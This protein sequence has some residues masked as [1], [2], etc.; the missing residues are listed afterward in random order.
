MPYPNRITMQFHRIMQHGSAMCNRELYMSWKSARGILLCPSSYGPPDHGTSTDYRDG[1]VHHALCHF[2]LRLIREHHN[3]QIVSCYLDMASSR[4]Q[5]MLLLNGII[6]ILFPSNKILQA[7]EQGY[8]SYSFNPCKTLVQ[9]MLYFPTTSC[10][11]VL[12]E[13][14]SPITQ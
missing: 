6:C 9:F 11:L 13:L 4:M 2:I 5:C 1:A 12:E 7:W 10:S 3:F 14:L 8:S